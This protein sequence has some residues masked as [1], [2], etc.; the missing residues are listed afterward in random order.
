MARPPKSSTL[1][2][3]ASAFQRIYHT[4]IAHGWVSDKLPVPKLNVR[5]VKSVVRPAFTQAEIEN[6]R[7]RLKTW[8]EGKRDVTLKVRQILRDY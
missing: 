5:G 3:F 6:I 2:T 1:L 4:A 8:W 7:E